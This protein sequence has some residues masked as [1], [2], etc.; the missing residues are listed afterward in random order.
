MAGGL[1]SS[2]KLPSWVLKRVEYAVTST[3]ANDTLIFSSRYTLNVPPRLSTEG[4]PIC[5]AKLMLDTYKSMGGK[6][7]DLYLEAASTDTIGSAVF[8]RLLFASLLEDKSVLVVSSDFHVERVKCIFKKVFS[9][10]PEIKISELKF[11][12]CISETKS[13]SRKRHELS[14]IKNFNRQFGPIAAMKDFLIKFV[15]EH[16]NYN[17]LYQSKNVYDD[18]MLY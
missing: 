4:Y 9:L 3:T 12:S 18:T 14:S 11:H 6:A 1:T 13:N 7:K 2:G 15:N 5:E 16:S 8:T 10:Q 17:P